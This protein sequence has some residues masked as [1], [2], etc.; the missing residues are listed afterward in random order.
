MTVNNRDDGCRT[1]K[2][3]KFTEERGQ[4]I[5][6]IRSLVEHYRDQ[7]MNVTVRQVYYQFVARGWAS[8]GDA[9]YNRVQGALND[10]RLAGLIPWNLVVD[11]GRGLRGLKTWGSPVEALA[12]RRREYRRDLWA[13]QP[14]R[15]EFWV[16]K[17]ALEGVV[18]DICGADDIRCDFYATKGYDSQSQQWAAGQRLADYVRAGQRP[19]IFHLGDHDPSGVDMTRDIGER[20]TMFVGVP[21]IVQRIALTMPQIERYDPPPFDVKGADSRA[22]D[23]RA[24][25]GDNAWELDALEP[26]VLR[27]LVHD[28]VARIRD[29]SA[30]SYSLVEEV[31]DRREMDDMLRAMGASLEEESDDE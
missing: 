19:I 6:R 14:F 29:D 28:A 27:D 16:E 8:S 26:S 20:L 10:G 12:Q 9:T 3:I 1:Y 11:R 30:W 13:D 18:G 31:D 5:G 4:L 23:Y 2:Q 17:Q 24:R 21:V 7:G 25:Y 22:A 15:P